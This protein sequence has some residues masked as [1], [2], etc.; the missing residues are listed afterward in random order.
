MDP[1]SNSNTARSF[2]DLTGI[3][4]MRRVG[5]LAAAALKR[6]DIRVR[7]MRVHSFETNLMYRVRS[8]TG[9]RFMLRMAYPGWRTADDLRAEAAWLDALHADTDIGAPRV[10]RSSNGESVLPMTGP[11]VPDTWYATLMTW[12][13]T[14]Y[15]NLDSGDLR[16]IHCDLW[17]EN[18]KIDGGTLRPFD[19]EDTIRGYRLHDIAMGM[20]DLLETAGPAAYEEL[21][22]AFR[23]GYERLLE[24]PPGNLEVLQIGR[25]LWQANYVARFER[26]HLGSLSE[27][28]GEVFRSFECTGVLRLTD[29]RPPENKLIA[30]RAERN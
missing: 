11:G 12:V 30:E 4:K 22:G 13:E 21:L 16:I 8:E 1:N 7:S 5:R 10:I 19:F 29:L 6:Y 3:G 20:L 15:G 24:W 14:E 17:H 26:E 9:E 18:I 25:L 28:Y 27:R 23:S 2:A